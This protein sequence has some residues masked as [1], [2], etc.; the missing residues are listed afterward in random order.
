MSWTVGQVDYTAPGSALG[1]VAQGVQQPIEFLI[2]A[3][4]E[5]DAVTRS[6]SAMPNPASDGIT[7]HLGGTSQGTTTYRVVD[8]TGQEVANGRF[9][10]ASAYIP[11]FALAP[12]TYLIHVLHGGSDTSVLRVIKH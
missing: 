11:F 9:T 6:I 7:V 1:T 5:E 8:L 2:L 10:G 12:S 4:V 3:T